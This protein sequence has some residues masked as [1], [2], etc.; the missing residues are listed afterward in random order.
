MADRDSDTSSTFAKTRSRAAHS[1]GEGEGYSPLDPCIIVIFGATGDLT[2]RMLMPALY[3]LRKSNSLPDSY[4]IVGCGR[5][6][7]SHEEFRLRVKE[8]L[9]KNSKQDLDLWEEFVNGLFYQKVQQDYPESYLELGNLL[10]S[11][12]VERKTKGNRLFYLA[13]PPSA[14]KS[15]SIDLGKAGLA[16]HKNEGQGWSRL[17]VEKPFGSDLK[18]SIEL[19]E[20]MRSSFTEGQIFRIDHYL[21][22]ETV[23]NFLIFRFANSIFEPLWNR[24]Y[25]DHVSIIAAEKLG[26]ENRASYY[27]NVGVLRDMFQNHLTQIL[28]LIA[29]EP[30]DRF[31]D[32]HVRDEKLKVF[33]SLRPFPLENLND[34]LVLG[35][36]TEGQID[37]YNV[38]GYRD[39]KG[40]SPDSLTP[41][42]GLLRVYIDNWR[43]QGTPFF[44]LSGKRLAKKITRIEIQFKRVPH[45]M[46]MGSL[47][48][49]SS[50]KLILSIYPEE[51]ISLTFQTK[52]PG[53]DMALRSVTMDFD[54]SQNYHGPILDAYEK[55]IV[56]AIRGNHMLF[57]RQDG[58]EA[59]WAFLDPIISDCESCYNRTEQLKFYKAG[60]NGPKEAQEMFEGPLKI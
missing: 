27:E 18:S 5:S 16:N 28:A 3:G 34:H 37:G 7:L 2:S 50:N 35:Q 22:K 47:G 46:F 25:V 52:I 10:N 8:S 14:Y 54:Y 23:Q 31:E 33:R 13:V 43:W 42:F 6:N 9:E 32:E 38:P 41:T 40:V 57:W 24:N 36:Y 4:A 30:P 56:D 48:A 21:A 29:M 59:S 44:L 11:L 12:D 51:H 1:A 55:S 17:V 19:K 58:V 26:I 45:S 60:S 20:A 15:I 53:A 49:I 39:E